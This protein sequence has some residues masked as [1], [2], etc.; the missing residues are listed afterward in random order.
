MV[1]GIDFASIILTLHSSL[2]NDQYLS[3][4]KNLINS[5]ELQDSLKATLITLQSFTLF[6]YFFHII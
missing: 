3:V 6:W 1:D 2:D 4:Q 5:V